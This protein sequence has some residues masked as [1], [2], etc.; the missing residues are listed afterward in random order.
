MCRKQVNKKIK[1]AIKIEQTRLY[2]DLVWGLY[3]KTAL[4]GRT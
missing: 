3:N 4:S 2:K 1:A